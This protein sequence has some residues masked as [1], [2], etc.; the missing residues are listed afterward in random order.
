MSPS[1]AA[2]IL[3]LGLAVA[4]VGCASVRSN[5]LATVPHVDLDRYAGR[6]YIISHV[7][8]FL[9]RGKVASYDTYARL[10]DGRL[11]NDFTFRPESV[12]APEKTWHGTA[13]V[14]DPQ[15]NATWKVSFFWPI[16]VTYKIFA[17]DPDYRWAVVGTKDAG[18][19]W[20]LSRDRQM[21]PEL[22]GKITRQ[23]TESAIATDKLE[24]VPQPGG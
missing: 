21:A 9:E 16:S 17:L 4:L 10:P 7:P 1:H 3:A 11:S 8:Y 12:T 13:E 20:V 15:T 6:W 5:T 18:L 22:Y 14:L 2:G 23:L 19:L 24:M